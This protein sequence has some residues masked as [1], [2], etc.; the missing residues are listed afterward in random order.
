MGENHLFAFYRFFSYG[1]SALFLG[2]LFALKLKTVEPNTQKRER[3][4][5]LSILLQSGSKGTALKDSCIAPPSPFIAGAVVPAAA[6]PQ[7]VSSVT[8]TPVFLSLAPASQQ[9]HF[10]VRLL[11]YSSTVVTKHHSQDN[12]LQ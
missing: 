1:D 11:S 12:L 8:V 2:Y 6:K 4:G 7:S 5:R 9:W 10:L 3:V